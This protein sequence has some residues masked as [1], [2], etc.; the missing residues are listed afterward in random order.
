M[1]RLFFIVF[2]TIICAGSV[3]SASTGEKGVNIRSDSISFDTNKDGYINLADIIP[4]HNHL[5][6]KSYLSSDELLKYDFNY[7][8]IS[9]NSDLKLFL[10]NHKP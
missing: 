8:G 1:K 9:D 3:V 2:A 6:G 5:I 4:L 7:D 10:E